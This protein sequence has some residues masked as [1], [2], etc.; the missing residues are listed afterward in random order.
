MG[1]NEN[2][3]EIT[4][5]I[6][7]TFIASRFQQEVGDE[8]SELVLSANI[9]TYGKSGIRRCKNVEFYLLYKYLCASVDGYP[10]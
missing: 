8:P 5:E 2:S 1:D 10:D 9:T 7:S 6:I 3:A 4:P